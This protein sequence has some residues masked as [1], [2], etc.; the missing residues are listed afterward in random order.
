M[1]PCAQYGQEQLVV[2][3]TDQVIIGQ[4]AA[5]MHGMGNTSTRALSFD[6]ALDPSQWLGKP[7]DYFVEPDFSAGA[8]RTSAVT[9]GGLASLVEEVMTQLRARQRHSDPHQSR[10]IGLMLIACETARM[11]V[12]EAARR[13]VVVGAP[14]ADVTAYVNLAR[15]AVEQVCLDVIAL[16]QRSLGLSAM[17]AS[18]PVEA[19]FRDLATY[20]RQPAADEALSEAAIHVAQQGRSLIGGI[21]A[22]T[23]DP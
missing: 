3:A 5:P 10:R 21:L 13:A 15:L 20:L 4:R 6:Q 16:V 8:W 7:G 19:M 11:W 14:S 23:A 18:N 17:M 1:N 12:E 9:A 2:I 22:G